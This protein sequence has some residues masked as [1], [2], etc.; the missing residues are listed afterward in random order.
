MRRGSPRQASRDSA[1]SAVRAMAA[2][3]RRA[4]AT[5]TDPG[6]VAGR[7]GQDRDRDRDRD[8]ANVKA[9]AANAAG[10]CTGPWSFVLGPWSVLSPWSVLGPWSLVRWIERPAWTG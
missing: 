7:A 2:A 8:A 4:S 5:A 9:A 1:D 3:G 6:R 10:S